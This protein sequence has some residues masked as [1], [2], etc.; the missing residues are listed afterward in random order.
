M[1]AGVRPVAAMVK[2]PSAKSSAPAIEVRPGMQPTVHA[3]GL[4]PIV[5]DIAVYCHS[6]SRTERQ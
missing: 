3:C 6:G 1:Y 2:V 5:L 4:D